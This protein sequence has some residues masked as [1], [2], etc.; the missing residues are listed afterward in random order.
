[1]AIFGTFG[2][3]RSINIPR[4]MATGK[5]YNSELNL[6]ILKII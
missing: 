5:Y 3:I 1:M 2:E 6:I 4:E